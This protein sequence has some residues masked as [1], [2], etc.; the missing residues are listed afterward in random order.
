[1]ID[2]ATKLEMRQILAQRV[3]ALEKESFATLWA[4]FTESSQGFLSRKVKPSAKGEEVVETQGASGMSYE[5]EIGVSVEHERDLHFFIS[6][7]DGKTGES[8]DA[9]TVIRRP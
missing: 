5:V 6:V 2:H 3:D 7:I 8:V 4:R 1:V 9:D